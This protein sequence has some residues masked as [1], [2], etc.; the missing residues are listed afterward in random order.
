MDEISTQ[1]KYYAETAA[2]YD[3][4]HVHNDDAHFFALCWLS[5]II[6]HIR[7][8][9]LLDIGSGTGRAVRFLKGR[10]PSLLVRGIEPVAALRE[11]AYEAGIARDELFDGDATKLGFATDSFD[12][13]CAFGALHHIRESGLAVSEMV[14]VARAG[15]FVSDG[16]NFGQGSATS[17]AIKHSL[18]AIG[19]WPLARFLKTKG[20]GFHFSEG[21]GVFYSYSAFDSVPALRQKFTSVH[22]MNT[23]DA[24]HDLLWSAPSVAIFAR[25]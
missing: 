5:A 8:E 13:V 25:R 3:E 17:R 7:A 14:R 4:M 11:R 21:D 1:R 24:G 6:D 22:Y 20:K 9:S 2:R 19:V 23:H 18:R 10:H 15:V 16:N 12:L